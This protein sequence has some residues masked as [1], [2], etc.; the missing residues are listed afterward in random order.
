[1]SPQVKIWLFRVLA[2]VTGVGLTAVLGI[3]ADMGHF[4]MWFPIVAAAQTFIVA[5]L[6]KLIAKWE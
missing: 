4:G 5:F 6:G 1:M 2:A 3:K